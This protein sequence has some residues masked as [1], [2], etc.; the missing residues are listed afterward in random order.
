[1]ARRESGKKTRARLLAAAGELFAEKGFQ[2]A[3]VAEICRRAKANV[4]AVSYY[5]G[6]KVSLY[7]EVWRKAFEDFTEKWP[8]PL[9]SKEVSSSEERLRSAIRGLVL[10][11]SSEKHSSASNRLYLFELARPT[12][13]VG[14]AWREIIEPR[15][16]YLM[17]LIREVIGPEASDEE[18][19]FCEMSIV[20]Q[21]RVFLTVSRSD[22]EHCL[23]RPLTADVI[24]RLADHITRFSL[25]G[26]LDIQNRLAAQALPL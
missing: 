8:F 1:M 4:A 3:T 21:C 26:V 23:A 25:A 14:E 17:D 6:D 22:L 11:L 18:V 15:R 7:M 5:F 2:E 12:G 13:L 9:P 24:D 20:N 16:R 19:L 10:E